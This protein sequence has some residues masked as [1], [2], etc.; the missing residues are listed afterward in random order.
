MLLVLKFFLLVM[1]GV[2]RVYVFLV[3]VLDGLL[4]L[5]IL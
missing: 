1:C 4:C 3:G 5:L 2:I